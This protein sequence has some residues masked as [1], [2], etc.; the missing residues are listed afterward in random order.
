MLGVWLSPTGNFAKHLEVMK[1]KA[2]KF[3]IHIRL[4]RLTPTGI[5]TFHKT[6]YFPSMRYSLAALAVDEEELHQL[7]TKIVQVPRSILH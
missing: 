6:M 4:S 3:S 7:Q 2:D 5:R 1:A